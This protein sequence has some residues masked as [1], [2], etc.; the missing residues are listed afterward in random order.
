MSKKIMKRSGKRKTYRKK[1]STTMVLN[2]ALGPFAQRYITTHKFSAVFSTAPANPIYRYQLNGL[3]DPDLANPVPRQPHG[4][5]QLATIYNRYRVISTKY[6]INF[7]NATVPTRVVALPANQNVVPTGVSDAVENPRAQWKVQVPGGD[8]QTLRGVVN[9]PSLMG[10]NK[11][12]Y[13]ADDRFQALTD[14]NPAELAVLNIF[15]AN[16][17]DEGTGIQ[18]TITFEY[19]VEYFDVKNLPQS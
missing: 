18:G 8:T 12:Q 19:L 10:R 15:S 11:D 3:F 6:N 2:K 1:K 9:M 13:M 4:F 17:A 5:D 7:Y 16:L 14:V